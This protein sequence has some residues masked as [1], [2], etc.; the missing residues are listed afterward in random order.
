MS[1][2]RISGYSLSVQLLTDGYTLAIEKPRWVYHQSVSPTLPFFPIT[3]SA[4]PVQKYH[5]L[6]FSSLHSSY[7]AES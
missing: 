6:A 3:T 5:S 2:D 1:A 7:F 4:S